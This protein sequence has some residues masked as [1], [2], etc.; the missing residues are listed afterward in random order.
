MDIIIDYCESAKAM[1]RTEEEYRKLGEVAYS[2]QGIMYSIV[3]ATE[4]VLKEKDN[5]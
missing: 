4:E 3:E 1:N 5:G 2:A